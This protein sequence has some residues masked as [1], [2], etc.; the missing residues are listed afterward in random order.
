[1]TSLAEDELRLLRDVLVKHDPARLPVL[2]TI[3]SEPLADADR[4]A[5]QLALGSELVSSGLDSNSEPNG[6]GTTIEALIDL[7]DRS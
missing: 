4:E 5:V 6:L 7:V 3:G 2:E 1:M